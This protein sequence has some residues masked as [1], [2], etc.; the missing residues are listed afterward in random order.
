MMLTDHVVLK[1]SIDGQSIRV[2]LDFYNE[3][4]N[5]ELTSRRLMSA[6]TVE[7][8]LSRSFQT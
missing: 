4:M 3:K 5:Q 7:K 8:P 2:L 6:V 1:G